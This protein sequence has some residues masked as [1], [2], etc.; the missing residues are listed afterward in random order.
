VFD[1]RCLDF[2]PAFLAIAEFVIVY[3]SQSSLR[4]CNLHAAPAFRRMCHR[5]LLKGVH[6]AEASDGLLIERDGFPLLFRSLCV[7]FQSGYALFQSDAKSFEL[8]V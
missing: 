4:L 5:L 2:L 8:H 3:G 1:P 7:S 6:P